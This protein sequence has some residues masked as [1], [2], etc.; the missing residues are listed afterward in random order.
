MLI[1]PSGPLMTDTLRILRLQ[2]KHGVNSP[3][4]DRVVCADQIEHVETLVQRQL[5][6]LFIPNDLRARVVGKVFL[7]LLVS[8][9]LDI[10]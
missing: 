2:A 4:V 7:N 6:L 3:V 8:L 10:S 1:V 9:R 5:S